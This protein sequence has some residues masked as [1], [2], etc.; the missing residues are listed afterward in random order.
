M[1]GWKIIHKDI[2]SNKMEFENICQK[3]SIIINQRGKSRAKK[4]I[5]YDAN[6]LFEEMVEEG[7]LTFSR[8]C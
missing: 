8:S 6:T 1:I 7:S 2:E 3:T 5:L 4:D